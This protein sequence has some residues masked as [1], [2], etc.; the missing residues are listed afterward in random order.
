MITGN[1]EWLKMMSLKLWH[2]TKR[3]RLVPG[4]A[5][6][7]IACLRVGIHQD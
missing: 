3:E 7:S 2:G 1:G 5:G 6:L 4:Y